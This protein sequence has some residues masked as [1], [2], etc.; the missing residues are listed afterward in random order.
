M[1]N[2]ARL[3]HAAGGNH[4]MK[5]VDAIESLGL[6]G[7]LGERHTPGA[8]CPGQDVALLELAFMPEE[9]L[10]RTRG[11]RG[12]DEDRNGRDLRSLHQQHEI[13]KQFLRTLNGEGW[14]DQRTVRV[15][16]GRCDLMRERLAS[17]LRRAIYPVTI[18]IGAL[19]DHIIPVRGGGRSLLEKLVVRAKVA[20]NKIR[21]GLSRP[22]S[23]STEAE[24][25]R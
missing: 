21:T 11:K 22:I 5:T 8:H 7:A 25:R 23:I 16:R 18:A 6:L 1:T 19:A 20:G 13:G 2:A 14:N 9:N 3:A 12:I 4:D 24:P 10:A 17:G 15:S